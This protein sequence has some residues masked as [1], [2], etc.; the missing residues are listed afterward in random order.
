MTLALDPSPS[1]QAKPP[2][3]NLAGLTRAEL[4][5]ALTDAAVVRPEKARPGPG[6]ALGT[7]GRRRGDYVPGVM[8]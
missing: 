1:A 7:T 6:R 8:R 4:V 3:R 2:V 5:Q